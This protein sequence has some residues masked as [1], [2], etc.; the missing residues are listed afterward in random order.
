MISL[1]PSETVKQHFVLILAMPRHLSFVIKHGSGLKNKSEGIRDLKESMFFL[2]V[3]CG[4]ETI[5][6]NLYLLSKHE[7]PVIISAIY[8]FASVSSKMYGLYLSTGL[9]DT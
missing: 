9:L 8:M 7:R 2:I 6:A 1:L 5:L 3:P 4:H